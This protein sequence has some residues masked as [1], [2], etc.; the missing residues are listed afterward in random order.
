LTKNATWSKRLRPS[1]SATGSDPVVTTQS[2]KHPADNGAGLTKGIIGLVNKCQRRKLDDW[3]ALRAWAWGASR[4]L[5]LRSRHT[6]P[7]RCPA[8]RMAYRLK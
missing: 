3:G 7:A 1:R 6:S 5:A 8:L 4:G 2:R